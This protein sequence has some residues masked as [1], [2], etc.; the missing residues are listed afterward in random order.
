MKPS[1]EPLEQL[2]YAECIEHP[3]S[4]VVDIG[5]VANLLTPGGTDQVAIII[6]PERIHWM[7]SPKSD[8]DFLDT[9]IWGMLYKDHQLIPAPDDADLQLDPTVH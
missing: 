7:A 2:F 8:W 1:N 9:L 4:C 5:L 6:S 3:G